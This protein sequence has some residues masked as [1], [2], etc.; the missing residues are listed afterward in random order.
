MSV[1]ERKWYS[2]SMLRIYLLG[3]PYFLLDETPV[4]FAALPK[5]WPL[6][7]YLLM[8]SSLPVKRETVAFTLWPDSPE[9]LARANLR[10]HL[11][12]L[13]RILPAEQSSSSPTA[14]S[15][16]DWLLV[17]PRTIQWNPECAYWLDLEEFERLSQSPDTLAEAATLYR[18]DFLKNSYDDW[19]FYER[20]RLRDLYLADL[21]QLTMRSRAERDYAL[22]ATYAHRMLELDP[23]REDALRQAVAMRYEAGDRS[24]ALQEYERFAHHLREELAVEP[25]PET[26]ALREAIIRQALLPAG[27]TREATNL[28]ASLVTGNIGKGPREHALLPFVGREAELEQL[29]GWW[30]RSARGKGGLVMLGGEAGIGKTRL[31]AQL[32]TQAEREGARVLRGNTTFAEPLPYQA[33]IEALRSELPLLAAL[34][35]EPLWLASVATLIPELRTRRGEGS[36]CLPSLLPLDPERERI[37]LF[38]GL[39]RCLEGLAR[40]RPLLIILEDLH[41]AGAATANLIEFL[42]RRASQHAVLIVATYREEE[43]PRAHPLRDLRR[44]LQREDQL[45]H[46]ALGPLHLGALE[47]MLA[48]MPA[49]STSVGPT[50]VG[51]STIA[52]KLYM[53]SEGQP[54]FVSELIRELL[55]VTPAQ[56]QTGQDE[57][58]QAPSRAYPPE[59]LAAPRGVRTLIAARVARL[60]PEARSIAEVASVV[61]AAFTVELVREV[62]GLDEFRV[63]H[64][65]DEMLDRGL[66]SEVAGRSQADYAFTHH[67][68]Q[69]SIYADMLHG[70]ASRRHRRLAQAM[71]EIYPQRRGELAGELALHF[72]LGN[73]PERAAQYYLE[74]ARVVLGLFADDEALGF[75]SRGLELSHDPSLR[76]DLLALRETVDSR[77][78]ER[79]AQQDDLTQLEALA[80]LLADEDHICEVLLRRA[81]F[82]SKLGERQ[83][84]A[85]LILALKERAAAS[86]NVRW[87]AA[88]LK[89]EA[90]HQ[91]LLSHYDLAMS[92]LEQS[93]ALRLA[94]DDTGGQVECYTLLSEIAAYNGHFE[95]AQA[96]LKQ[97]TSVAGSQANRSLLVRT[98]RAAS[99]AAI[100][101][102]EI[103]TAYNLGMQM[104]DLCSSIGDREGE[105]DAHTRVATAASRLFHVEE[106]SRHYEQAEALYAMLGNRRGQAAVL[107]NAGMLAANLGHYA[108]AIEASMR[109]EA[110]FKGLDDIRG[111]TVSLVNIA[112]HSLRKGDYRAA[113]SSGIR[114][115]KSARIMKNPVFEAYAL[116]NLGAAELELGQSRQAITHMEEGL[117]IRREVGQAAVELA[118]DL[119]DL[120]IAYLRAGNLASAQETAD[121]MLNL[122]AAD[123]EH[124]T[125]PQYILWAAAQTYRSLG[126]VERGNELLVRAYMVM[127]EK[128]DSIPDPDSRNTF[129]Q[130]PYNRDLQAAYERGEW[131]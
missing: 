93:L 82:Q 7:A 26:V 77:H 4:E 104:L 13:K 19:L 120:T 35:I 113:R 23:F 109:A 97:A 114:A 103:D 11:H 6:W 8:H 56:E 17:T 18:G 66:V 75:V 51:V 86:G 55:E 72:D 44:R 85:E 42:A 71:E 30:S 48:Q 1:N 5:I 78:G 52:R 107:V 49:L 14:S 31:A 121:E 25:M 122:L 28:T 89:A 60:S 106:A 67:L 36:G 129:A 20:E 94:L 62:S 33:L 43:T 118:T 10:R 96:L 34:E 101:Q 123:A 117:A 74:A 130:L 45:R 105:A 15:G 126:Q 59:S 116:A 39:A 12:D 131:P 73:E 100:V 53:E 92:T 47:S 91:V 119:C 102:V 9:V 29:R 63:L 16:G 95:E 112:V 111:Q 76:F 21:N 87:Q 99:I 88:A 61:G 57:A 24:G 2:V 108:E 115:L 83:S 110:L 65:L 27:A 22:A 32:G 125:Y 69:A 3:R 68:I 81:L 128:K 90:D 58:S 80:V 70:L 46:L 40:P 79:Q 50:D 127:Q 54:F 64:S 98:L 41:W 38:E 84:E 37:R 124:M